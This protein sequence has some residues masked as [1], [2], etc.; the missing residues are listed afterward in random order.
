MQLPTARVCVCSYNAPSRYIH[1]QSVG[2]CA[3]Q[4]NDLKSS[5][6]YYLVPINCEFLYMYIC[7]YERLYI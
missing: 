3:C 5:F 1:N 6:S 2:V 7:T 4:P